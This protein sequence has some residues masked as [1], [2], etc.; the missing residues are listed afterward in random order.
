M[1]V[2]SRAIVMHPLRHRGLLVRFTFHVLSYYRAVIE[3]SSVFQA[4]LS[5][6]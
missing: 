4:D 5:L 6:S 3:I 1:V 2:V